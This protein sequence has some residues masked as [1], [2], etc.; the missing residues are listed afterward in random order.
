ML[1]HTLTPA[2]PLSNG[3][4]GFRRWSTT[5]TDDLSFTLKVSIKFSW[6]RCS[7]TP[8]SW[9]CSHLTT[10]LT[11]RIHTHLWLPGSWRTPLY[12]QLR[13]SSPRC[14]WPSHRFSRHAC[15]DGRPLLPRHPWGRCLGHNCH[16]KHRACHGAPRL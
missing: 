15:W 7:Q 9:L 5:S 14:L 4:S 6:G 1:G 8:T 12:R 2:I 11:C 16:L 10:P 13:T 3:W